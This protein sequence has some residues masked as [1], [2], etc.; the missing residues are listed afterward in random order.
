MLLAETS[1]S[2][3][4]LLHGKE[5]QNAAWLR[6]SSARL[7]AGSE[8]AEDR[9]RC[10]PDETSD[11]SYTKCAGLFT[12]VSGTLFT[13]DSL[14]GAILGERNLCRTRRMTRHVAAV[15]YAMADLFAVLGESPRARVGSLGERARRGNKADLAAN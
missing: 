10:R 7:S 8:S 13:R 1:E 4:N 5:E 2:E 12:T 6:G 3:R 14:N 9:R 15:S 11:F